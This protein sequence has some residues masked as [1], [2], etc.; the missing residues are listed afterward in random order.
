[1]HNE[2]ADDLAMKDE[3]LSQIVFTVYNRKKHY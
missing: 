1:M 3:K 2:T